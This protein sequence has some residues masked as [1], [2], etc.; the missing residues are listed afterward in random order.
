ME[1]AVNLLAQPQGRTLAQPPKRSRQPVLLVEGLLAPWLAQPSTSWEPYDLNDGTSVVL[2]EGGP[3]TEARV[4]NRVTATGSPRRRRYSASQELHS[5]RTSGG[6]TT[7]PPGPTRGDGGHRGP[8][9]TVLDRLRDPD[10][11]LLGGQLAARWHGGAPALSNDVEFLTNPP[12][13]T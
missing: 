10:Q 9:S 4:V 8:H 1:P 6:R 3:H 5:S 12:A 7:A 2:P 11:A 13:A